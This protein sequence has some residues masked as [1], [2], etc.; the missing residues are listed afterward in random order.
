MGRRPDCPFT[1]FI[2]ATKKTVPGLEV[3]MDVRVTDSVPSA[4]TPNTSQGTSQ[5]PQPII[6]KTGSLWTPRDCRIQRTTPNG[7]TYKEFTKC[8]TLILTV[9]KSYPIKTL[10]LTVSKSYPIKTLQREI[11]P[12]VV[13]R[14]PFF[15][16]PPSCSSQKNISANKHT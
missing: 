8:L 4:Q 14:L 9:S 2:H 16:F 7:E 6:D 15:I 13:K 10:H 3:I 1:S 12:Y 11:L 5:D